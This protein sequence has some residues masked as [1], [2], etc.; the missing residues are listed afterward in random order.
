NERRRYLTTL[1]DQAKALA[2]ALGP[3]DPAWADKRRLAA[4]GDFERAVKEQLPAEPE[5]QAL[6]RQLGARPPDKSA[7]VA[8]L[9]SLAALLDRRAGEAMAPAAAPAKQ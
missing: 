7:L 2:R 3:E 6:G 9:Q 4:V 8:S 5:V 1:R